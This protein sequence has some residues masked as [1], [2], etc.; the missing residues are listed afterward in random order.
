M[1]IPDLKEDQVLQEVELELREGGGA[2][3]VDEEAEKS[4]AA[5]PEEHV[6]LESLAA[7]SKTAEEWEAEFDPMRS[8]WAPRAAWCDAKDLFDTESV[9]TRRFEA[10]LKRAISLGM[11][12]EIGIATIVLVFDVLLHGRYVNEA[13]INWCTAFTPTMIKRDATVACL[14]RQPSD[15]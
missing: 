4:K 7:Q 13:T 15:M 8:L 3:Q 11:S 2:A 9:I 1:D 14:H 5:T 12:R 6:N 10:D